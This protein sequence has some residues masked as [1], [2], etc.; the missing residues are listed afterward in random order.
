MSIDAP[1]AKVV[2]SSQSRKGGA[3]KG[4]R[5]GGRTAGTPNKLTKDLRESIVAAA[6]AAH[7]DGMIG[8]LTQQARENP[9]SFMALLGKT[10]PK[11]ITGKDGKDLFPTK[12]KIELVNP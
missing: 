4:E 1:L 3:K 10:V 8:Y 9:N 12:I 5:R 6:N 7:D 2:K 11:E